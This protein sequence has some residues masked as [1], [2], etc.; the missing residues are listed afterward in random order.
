MLSFC[1]QIWDLGCAL[2]EGMTHLR[3]NEWGSEAYSGICLCTTEGGGV[4]WA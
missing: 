3:T 1:A 4:V 2:R